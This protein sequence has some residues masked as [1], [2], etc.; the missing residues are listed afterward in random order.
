VCRPTAPSRGDR[1]RSGR[2]ARR[3]GA[4]FEIPAKV[5]GRG[6][7]KNALLQ[8]F[9][10]ASAGSKQLVLVTGYAGVG[11]SSLVYEMHEPIV[12]RRAWFASGKFHQL[13][14]HV[15]YQALAQA[16]DALVQQVLAAP[17]PTLVA[18]RGQLAES[19]GSDVAALAQVVPTLATLLGEG[20]PLPELPSPETE[21]RFNHAV[22]AFLRAFARPGAPLVAVLRRSA[23]G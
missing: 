2:T 4:R 10:R 12:Q 21:A 7:E 18:S 19:L 6:A 9:E 13:T 14:Q 3:R 8:A 5:Y 1:R 17:Q 23:V 22:V 15:P 11:K 16:F 20:S